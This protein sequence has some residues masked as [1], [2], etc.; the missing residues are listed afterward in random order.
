MALTRLSDMA[1]PGVEPGTRSSPGASLP[2]SLW[3]ESPYVP[4]AVRRVAM[5]Y[6]LT[7]EDCADIV[8]ELQVVLL[9]TDPDRPLN[10]TWIFQTASHKAADVVRRRL[11]AA[12]CEIGAPA[13]SPPV[14]E[15]VPELLC[16]L[17]AKA[18]QLPPK[19]KAFY[20]L[21]YGQGLS[22]RDVARRL[23]ACRASVRWLER[24]CVE[25]LRRI[26]RPAPDGR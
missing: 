7:G 21:R 18:A 4:R 8:Q 24:Q 16:L 10:A 6:S 3:L 13:P 26:G 19:L 5:R 15:R 14:F 12:A 22:Q 25:R 2:A 23:G 1:A 20:D 17:R 9:Q 11:R